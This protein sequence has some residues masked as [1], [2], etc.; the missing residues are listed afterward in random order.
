[1]VSLVKPASRCRSR[2]CWPTPDLDAVPKPAGSGRFPR[3][4]QKQ[5]GQSTRAWWLL[6]ELM[7]RQQY[8]GAQTVLAPVPTS[9]PGTPEGGELSAQKVAVFVFWAY[10]RRVSEKAGAVGKNSSQYRNVANAIEPHSG[11]LRFFTRGL[12]SLLSAEL[13]S[14]QRRRSAIGD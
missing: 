14:N 2:N 9:T 1:L 8:A 7:R 6:R 10:A 13:L 12:L 11:S 3:V 5:T 4:P